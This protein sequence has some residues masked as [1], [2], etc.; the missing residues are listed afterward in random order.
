MHTN[1][2]VYAMHEPQVPLCGAAAS[3]SASTS[4]SASACWRWRM[5]NA[6]ALL[7]YFIILAAFCGEYVCTFY[8]KCYY[9]AFLCSCTYIHAHMHTCILYARVFSLAST[10]CLLCAYLFI[11]YYYWFLFVGF[12]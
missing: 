8:Y 10:H 12:Y 7:Y 9:Y 1:T 4:A 6:C 3:V 2:R 11:N 5:S